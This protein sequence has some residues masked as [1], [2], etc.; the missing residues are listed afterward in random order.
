MSGMAAQE[1]VIGVGCFA[2]AHACDGG[3]SHDL[4]LERRQLHE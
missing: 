1:V 3:L 2:L 4:W